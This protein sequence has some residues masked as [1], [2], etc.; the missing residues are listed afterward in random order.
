LADE[1]KNEESLAEREAK[2]KKEESDG[3]P[4]TEWKRWLLKQRWMK[5]EVIE[6]AKA[7]KAGRAELRKVM[8]LMTR[9]LGQV[10]NTRESILRIVSGQ[11]F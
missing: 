4:S 6:V 5:R 2:E 7:D 9:G 10:V 3:T 8:R 11:F 1:K